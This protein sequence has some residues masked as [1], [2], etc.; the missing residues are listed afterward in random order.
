MERTS[1]LPEYRTGTI[2]W[3]LYER[4]RH[5]SSVL[6]GKPGNTLDWDLCAI[7]SGTLMAAPQLQGI[8]H[9]KFAVSDL[10]VSLDFYQRAFDANRIPRADH[11]RES[12]GTLYAYILD[13]PGLGAHLELRL[14]PVRAAANAHFDPVTVAV[15]DGSTLAEWDAHLNVQKIAHS[16]II[17]AI[18]A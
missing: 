3:R 10:A 14:N 16:P 8:H 12:D 5:R 6:S 18:Q 15:A 9:L 7:T 1:A 4:S 17:T 2:G 13:V 11:R